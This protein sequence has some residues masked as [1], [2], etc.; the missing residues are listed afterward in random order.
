M[1]GGFT[2]GF[3]M[4]LVVAVIGCH[5]RSSSVVTLARP[6]SSSSLKITDR[7]F[8]SA[9]P[10]LWNQFL[11]SLRQP[12]AGTSSSISDSPISSSITSSSSDSPLCSSI[13]PSLFHFRFKTYLFDK[14]STPH[15]P[16]VVSRLPPG[17]PSRSRP[18]WTKFFKHTNKSDTADRQ[19]VRHWAY[20]LRYCS[21]SELAPCWRKNE[22]DRTYMYISRRTTIR[23]RKQGR[24]SFQQ[25][26]TI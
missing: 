7:S 13:T 18:K 14:F 3:A 24:R 15:P 1:P 6:P 4:H 22:E 12:H 25:H 17:L 16:P 8:R 23:P 21:T 2:L 11:L 20:I 10:C 9:L 19:T 5:S 26:Q